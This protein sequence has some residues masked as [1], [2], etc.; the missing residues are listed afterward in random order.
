[1]VFLFN[2]ENVLDQL[3][4]VRIVIDACNDVVLYHLGCDLRYVS[5]GKRVS[6]TK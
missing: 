1:M 4:K 5:C 2:V 3:N 6:E